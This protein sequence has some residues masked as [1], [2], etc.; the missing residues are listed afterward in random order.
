MA[1]TVFSIQLVNDVRLLIQEGKQDEIMADSYEI[2]NGC[3]HIPS[4]TD[5]ST[6]I[7]LTNVKAI[8]ARVR[9]R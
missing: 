5:Y 9:Y 2:K 8:V 4:E 6:I 3:V 7:P 1:A